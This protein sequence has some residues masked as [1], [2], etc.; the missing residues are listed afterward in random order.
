MIAPKSEWV[1]ADFNGLFSKVVCLSH[2][3]TCEDA[4]GNIVALT[5]GM[6]LTAFDEDEENGVRDDLFATGT[7][8]RAPDWLQ[9]HG[10]RWVLRIDEDGVRH[11]SDFQ[12]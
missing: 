7:V 5:E 11:E 6:F 10:S 4:E 2:N 8:E 1:H 3:D 12:T 9:D